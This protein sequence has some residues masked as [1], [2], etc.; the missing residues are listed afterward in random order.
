MGEKRGIE[1]QLRVHYHG[2]WVKVYP[3]PE[4]TLAAKKRLIEAL[5]HRLFDLAEYGINIP[6]NRL[7]E[8]RRAY[9]IETDP[10]R[11][12]VNGAM[13]AGA[14]FNRAT[15]ILTTLV[16]LQTDGADIQHDNPLMR[17][18]GAC[19]QESLE[20]GTLVRHVSGEEGID[21]LWGEPFKVFCIPIEEFFESRYI[22]IAL[23]MRDI[24][25]I[26]GTLIATFAD[27]NRFDG[28]APLIR[29]FSAAAR[30]KCETLHADPDIFNVWPALLVAGQRLHAFRPLGQTGLDDATQRELIRGLNLIRKGHDLIFHITRARVPMPKSTRNFIEECQRHQAGNLSVVDAA[31]SQCRV[32]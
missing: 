5:A 14:L 3:V 23:T 13:L 10:E 27:D 29:D 1:G 28:L 9:A 20:L 18:C 16:E 22:K 2:Y 17:E 30:D 31:G 6:A 24:D 12:R 25:G 8:A 26:A 19:L 4:D 32:A 7:D 21:E 15:E 11:R